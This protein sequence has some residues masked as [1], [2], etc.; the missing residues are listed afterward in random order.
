[1][2]RR[3]QP[4]LPAPAPKRPA[5]AAGV[6]PLLGLGIAAALVAVSPAVGAFSEAGATASGGGPGAPESVLTAR[7]IAAANGTGGTHDPAYDGQPTGGAYAPDGAWPGDGA[8]A[9]THA[10]HAGYGDAWAE[11]GPAYG[12]HLAGEHYYAPLVHSELYEPAYGQ[13]LAGEHYYAPGAGPA[14]SYSAAASDHAGLDVAP[15]PLPAGDGGTGTGAATQAWAHAEPYAGGAAAYTA[16]GASDGGA[17]AA[18]PANASDGDTMLSDMPESF[19]SPALPERDGE[20]GEDARM[21]GSLSAENG[22]AGNVSVA[23]TPMPAALGAAHAEAA[24]SGSG[25]C[26]PGRDPYLDPASGLDP[27]LESEMNARIDALY[28]RV[29][30]VMAEYG[31]VYKEPGLT[32]EQRDEMQARLDGVDARRGQL[33]DELAQLGMAERASPGGLL[34]PA[35]LQAVDIMVGD[36]ADEIMREY[37]FVIE[38]PRLS[39]EDEAAMSKRLDAVYA[40]MGLVFEEYHALAEGE[41]LCAPAP[42][43]PGGNG[44]A[45][46]HGPGSTLPDGGLLAEIDAL[47]AEIDA[48][49]AEYEFVYGEP[50]L[51]DEQ[52]RQIDARMEELGDRHMAAV[53][54]I[55]ARM[56]ALL[57]NASGPLADAIR[58]DQRLADAIRDDQRLAEKMQAEYDAIMAEYGLDIA[59][60]ELS[61]KDMAAMEERLE[62]LYEKLDAAYARLYAELGEGGN[63]DITGGIGIAATV[64]PD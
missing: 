35:T 21:G 7:I 8:A 46:E 9:H 1:M 41:A 47:H 3:R 43:A 56:A 11:H 2:L 50:D 64:Q 32:D 26:D 28:A 51:T 42:A 52:I 33:L 25:A 62:P 54:E 24:A 13:H 34:L 27:K 4:S 30:A 58:D 19:G 40:K 17:P 15:M 16:A 36:L 22:T 14:P 38:T 61:A 44:T 23:P 49:M 55:A 53:D 63:G 20:P 48:V 60:P 37:G 18:W 10:A 6:W 29:D 12:Q 59:Y 39:A 31:F 57:S 45:A 5:K